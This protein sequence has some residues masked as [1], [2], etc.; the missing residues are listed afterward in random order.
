VALGCAEDR[1]F[2][3]RLD[4]VFRL[5]PGGAKHQR[6]PAPRLEPAHIGDRDWH[7]DYA[8]FLLSLRARLR[9]IPKNG[10]RMDLL[11]RLRREMEN[12]PQRSRKGRRKGH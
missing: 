5:T 9:Q 10:A 11:N 6:G 8:A 4:E 1:I 7:N 2:T 12:P 3:P